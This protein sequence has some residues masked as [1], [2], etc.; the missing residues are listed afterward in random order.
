MT[1]SARKAPFRTRKRKAK[2][3]F[4]ATKSAKASRLRRRKYALIRRFDFPEEI[5]GGSL[6]Q[7][8]R[9]CGKATCRCASGLGHPQW[10]LTF[11]VRGTKH[12]QALP[13]DAVPA[14]RPLIERGRDYRD[15]VSELLA[16]NAQ[17]VSLWRQRERTRR[18]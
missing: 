16:I 15:A 4:F 2:S 1:K 8:R 9:S 3:A 12:V 13:A 17:L 10:V 7:T 11:S 18:R 14:L 5:L 6:T